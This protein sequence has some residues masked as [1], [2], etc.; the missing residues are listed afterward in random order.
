MRSGINAVRRNL[1]LYDSFR[2]EVQ[3]VLCRSSDG[4]IFREHH[5]TVVTAAYSELI[6]GTDHTE[7][8]YPANLAF[9]NLE[10][11]REDGSYLSEQNF[12]PCSNIGRAA[13]NREKFP[14]AGIHLGNVKMV[15]IRMRLAFNDFCHHHA[16]E[17]AGNLFLLL[18]AVNFDSNGCHR[19]G[20]LRRTERHIK[21]IFKP[22]V[23][24]FHIFILNLQD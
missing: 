4:S 13:N 15:R 17:S 21:I 5:D 18:H 3:P 10:I 6:L 23:T 9:L 7:R 12:L 1:I 14:R 24:E 2:L 16:G 20:S 8:F 11:A 22:I 19:F